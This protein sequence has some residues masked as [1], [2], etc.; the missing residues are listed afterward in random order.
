MAVAFS[1][2]AF[3]PI[4]S[5][6]SIIWLAHPVAAAGCIGPLH[7]EQLSYLACLRVV[8]VGED[9]KDIL[10]DEPLG[11]TAQGFQALGPDVPANRLLTHI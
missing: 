11:P 1:V 10:R 5:M 4:R 2:E 6:C 8:A 7:L 9:H 3:I